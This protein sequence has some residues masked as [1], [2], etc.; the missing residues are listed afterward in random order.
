MMIIDLGCVW[1][2]EYSQF[3]SKLQAY[4]GA[5]TNE[6]RFDLFLQVFI[7]FIHNLFPFL[8]SCLFKLFT[9]S[10]F[11][12]CLLFLIQWG[13]T[14]RVR[15]EG[16]AHQCHHHLPHPLLPKLIPQLSVAL[17]LPIRTP[18]CRIRHWL[19]VS[20]LNTSF[21]MPLVTAFCKSFT[22]MPFPSSPA[23]LSL[24]HPHA[25]PFLTRMPFPSSPACLSLP[26]HAFPFFAC[27][28]LLCMHAFPRLMCMPFLVLIFWV[29][30]EIFQIK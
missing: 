16:I 23:C 19:L 17:L 26:L 7:H 8:S 20:W 5:E 30:K 27:L 11:L 29:G 4:F 12:S 10:Q 13:D 2:D 9:I 6:R 14:D 24:P 15:R 1:N 3:D 22:C 25:F 21:C 28:S 18:L